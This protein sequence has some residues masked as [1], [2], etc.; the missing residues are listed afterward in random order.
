[1]PTT[2]EQLLSEDSEF[3]ADLRLLAAEAARHVRDAVGRALDDGPPGDVPPKHHSFE[4]ELYRRLARIPVSKRQRLVARAHAQL[5]GRESQPLGGSLRDAARPRASAPL[6]AQVRQLVKSEMIAAPA[7]RVAERLQRLSMSPD[8][9][10]VG[11]LLDDQADARKLRPTKVSLRIKK[12]TCRNKTTDLGRDEIKLAVI[13]HD[14][15]RK[16]DALTGPIDVGEFRDGEVRVLDRE[17]ARFTPVDGMWSDAMY[18]ATLFLAEADHGGMADYI[19]RQGLDSH[20]MIDLLVAASGTSVLSMIGIDIGADRAF[21][22]AKIVAALALGLG[23]LFAAGVATPTVGGVALGGAA[24]GALGVLLLKVLKHVVV[25]MFLDWLSDLYHDENFKPQ[26]A[27]V[28][29]SVPDSKASQAIVRHTGQVTFSLSETSWGSTNVARYIVEYEWVIRYEQGTGAG[30]SPPKPTEASGARAIKNLDKIEHIV[31]LMLENRSFDHMLGFLTADRG[32]P[33]FTDPF[34][35]SRFCV[36]PAGALPGLPALKVGVGHCASTQTLNDPGHEAE[37]VLRQATGS[38]DGWPD[39]GQFAA[40]RDEGKTMRGF[41]EDYLRK[42]VEFGD[43]GFT[44]GEQP[45]AAQLARLKQQLAD[46]M[47]YHPADHVPAFD[48]L[49]TEFAVCDRWFS[50]FPGNTWVN[51]TIAMAGRPALKNGVYVTDNDMPFDVPS[52]FHVLDQHRYRGAAI[53]WACYSQ[54][55]P[56]LLMVDASYS[57]ELL[58]LTSGAPGRLRTI[59]RFF[60]DAAAGRLP[61]VS[62]IDPNFVD[63]GDMRENLSGWD[64]DLDTD[65]YRLAHLFATN[66]ANDDHPPTDVTHAQSFVLAVFRALMNGKAWPKTMLVVTYDEHGGFYDHVTPPYTAAPESV[67]FRSLG[68]R[69]P[70][71]VVSPWVDRQLVSSTQFDH[72]SII[73]TILLK[74]CRGAQ[75]QLPPMTARVGAANHLGGLLNATQPRMTASGPPASKTRRAFVSS[76]CDGLDLLM[77][78]RQL[79]AI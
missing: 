55:V 57:G 53:D 63:I 39:A 51:R 2:P 24:L 78:A 52:L 14:I 20:E 31:V 1:M 7:T 58:R 30:V 18:V 40:L 69:V 6:F 44:P 66:T 15:Y 3:A 34:D 32:R 48:L 76:V 59:E 47:N 10:G 50:S 8:V 65:G 75:G 68:V 41:I 13:G 72:A 46:V 43:L 60:S 54:D 56:S 45:S 4:A 29:L 25:D 74:F 49:A 17:V 62:W 71:L 35:T 28:H 61:H 23:P 77:R 42:L 21:E 27:S 73:K 16:K 64:G 9:P 26:L 79:R 36:V 11:K 33:G 19:A 38:T 67:A 12:V 37:N 5:V 70:A 22:P